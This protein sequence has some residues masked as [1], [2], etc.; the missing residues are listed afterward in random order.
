MKYTKDADDIKI[1]QYDLQN[2][3][4]LKHLRDLSAFKFAIGDVLVRDEKRG[5]QWVVQ[6]GNGG[7]PYKWVYIFENELG[8]GYFKCLSINGKRFIHNAICAVEF[9]PATTR[10]RLDPE[11]ADHIMLGDANA[12]FD[13]ISNHKALKKKREKMN[14][15]NDKLAADTSNVVAIAAW[16][17][18]L[19]PGDNLW[20][21]YTRQVEKEPHV[22]LS[23]KIGGSNGLAIEDSYV[24]LQHPTRTR[25]FHIRAKD[26]LN[27]W[28]YLTRPQFF[29]DIL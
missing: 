6:A 21:S 27:M 15:E 28:I 25:T 19:K 16:M 4:T 8:I 20:R 17:M 29:E 26:T 2:N 3:R 14:H 1:E 5:D 18:T 11:Y 9:D 24:E 22:V 10:F 23:V 12:E 7:L 13:V